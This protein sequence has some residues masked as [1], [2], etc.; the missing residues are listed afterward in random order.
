MRVFLVWIGT[1]PHRIHYEVLSY[2]RAT[3]MMRVRCRDGTEYDRSFNPNLKYNK[4]DFKLVT[5][6]DDEDA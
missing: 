1:E 6:E 5:T 4:T 2:D 3:H